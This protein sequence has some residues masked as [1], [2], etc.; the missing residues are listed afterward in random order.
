MYSTYTFCLPAGFIPPSSGT[1]YINGKDIRTDIDSV[2]ESLGLC[3]QHNIL[4]GTLTVEE[5]LIFFAKVSL[6]ARLPLC[7]GWSVYS[8]VS[9]F[10]SVSL[11]AR[12]PLR[13]GWSVYSL[14]S[15]FA[16]VSLCACLNSSLPMSVSELVLTHLCQGQ[17]LCLSPTLPGSV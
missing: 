7:Q 2:R 1:A 10:A 9:L 8:L 15:L 3:P 14:V 4:F 13:Q 5:H 17:S 12:L 6:C 16:S 11:C